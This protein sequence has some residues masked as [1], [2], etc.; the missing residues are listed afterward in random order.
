MNQFLIQ[1]CHI[2]VW[3]S[4]EQYRFAVETLV[5][6]EESYR[7]NASIMLTPAL[8]AHWVMNHIV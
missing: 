3:N 8:V 7:C 4:G 2:V 5:V 1:F 6:T